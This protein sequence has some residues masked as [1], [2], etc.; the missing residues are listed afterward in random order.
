MK[1]SWF[2]I[3]HHGWQNLSRGRP[4]GR[5]LLE[6]VQNAFDERV[7]NVDIRF[8]SSAIT[9]EDDNERGFE[10]RRL[11]YTVFLSA[12]RQDPTKRGRLGRGL[13]ELIAAMDTATVETA[14]V[15]VRFSEGG[16]TEEENTRTRG[17]RL[18]LERAFTTRE[19]DEARELL[20][21][22]IPPR[23]VCLRVDG[24][25]ATRPKLLLTLPSCELESVSV[26]DG[27]ER[28]V[29]SNTTV[30]LYE[31]RRD[32]EAQLFEMGIPIEGWDVPWHVDI[33]QRVPLLDGR[34]AVKDAYKL[35]LKA[36]LLE[37]MIQRYLDKN[38]L[39]A[40]WV[41]DVIGRFPLKS[42]VIDAYVS[43]AFPRGAVLG[44]SRRANDRARQLNAHVIESSGVSHSAY[45]AFARVMET[46]DDYVRR[47]A[48]EF[49]IEHVEPNEEQARFARSLKWLAREIAGS[50]IRVNFFAQDP[51]DSGLLEDAR[52]NR[53]LRLLSFNVRGPL[54]YDDILDPYTLGVALHEL[55]H[56]DSAE[57][58]YRFIDRL[59]LLAGQVTRLIAEDPTVA[60]RLRS[61]DFQT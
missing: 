15:T 25:E 11:I 54:R 14:G 10:D 58:D 4:L 24:R 47:R 57:H 33:A 59:Q 5:L 42:T 61:G 19:L 9:I 55:A 36:F 34:D 52:A 22:C 35:N 48:K 40:D 41:L 30:S 38:D 23:D 20:R 44:G 53:E 37:S 43:R 1:A 17:T 56:L 18:V 32:Q 16:R 7:A 26:V 8:T 3:S 60:V 12:K 50:V 39:R 31:P 45:L 21:S 6:A 51:S 13:K 46:A 28:A 27:V 2:E 29:L 49:E